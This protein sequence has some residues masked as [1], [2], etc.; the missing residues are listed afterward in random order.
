MTLSF[1]ESHISRKTS[2]MWG[3][4]HL[5]EG[6]T[7]DRPPR[8]SQATRRGGGLW[9]DSAFR[10]G[11]FRS[12]GSAVRRGGPGRHE[13]CHQAYCPAHYGRGA[14]LSETNWTA[15]AARG[16][17]RGSILRFH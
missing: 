2:E 7:F 6:D 12:G 8:C 17:R 15:L 11:A 9:A 1:V 4:R 3:T 10:S 13:D 5:L 16:L 14:A